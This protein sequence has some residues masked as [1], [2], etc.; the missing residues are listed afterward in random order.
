MSSRRLT[1]TSDRQPFPSREYVANYLANCLI[2]LIIPDPIPTSPT[3][4]GDRSLGETLTDGLRRRSMA[5]ARFPYLLITLAI[6]FASGFFFE[7]IVLSPMALIR[8]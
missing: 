1:D 4:L 6:P 7:K 5:I 8:F 2:L 3:T